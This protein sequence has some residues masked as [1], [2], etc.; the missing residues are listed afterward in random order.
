MGTRKHFRLISQRNRLNEKGGF[1]VSFLKGS[2]DF[3]TATNCFRVATFKYSIG[4]DS[5]Y[6]TEALREL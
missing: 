3:S 4:F 5:Q 6:Q 1:F 2:D